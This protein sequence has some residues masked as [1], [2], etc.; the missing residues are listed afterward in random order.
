MNF[1]ENIRSMNDL[2]SSASKISNNIQSGNITSMKSVHFNNC[3][4]SNSNKI[5]P[6]TASRRHPQWNIQNS[7]IA[8]RK[9]FV[10]SFDLCRLS[11]N[12]ISNEVS[13]G[14]RVAQDKNI[15]SI[16]PGKKIPLS[17]RGSTSR[18]VIIF[19]SKLEYKM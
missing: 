14:N 7:L 17:S 11:Q 1:N 8:K 4:S 2:K 18:N 15:L 3:T 9:L 12:Y 5:R 6:L 13:Q 19:T 10:I 16:S